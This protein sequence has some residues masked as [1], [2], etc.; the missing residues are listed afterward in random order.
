MQ[1]QVFAAPANCLSSQNVTSLMLL[2]TS[3]QPKDERLYIPYV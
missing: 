2:V 3:C 1:L